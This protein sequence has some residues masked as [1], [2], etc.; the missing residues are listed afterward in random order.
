[1]KVNGGGGGVE[2][3]RWS[4]EKWLGG[5]GIMEGEGKEKSRRERG[6]D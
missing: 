2:V 1:V 3:Y 4:V 6:D 5:K